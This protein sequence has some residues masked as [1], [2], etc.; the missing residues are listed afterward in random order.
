MNAA[1][2]CQ[3]LKSMA[4][5]LGFAPQNLFYLIAQRDKLYQA[6]KIKKK[7]DENKFREIFIPCS[8]LKGVQRQILD[9]ILCKH[10]PSQFAYAYVKGRSLTMAAKKL[11]GQQSV[12]KID[13]K[14]FFPSIKENRIFGLFRS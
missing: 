3:D 6:A 14:D 13:L 9:S 10:E 12:L 11:V 4:R 2:H 1:A 8:E 5:F 7:T